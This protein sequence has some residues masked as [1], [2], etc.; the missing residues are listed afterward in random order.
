M[1]TDRR[2]DMTKIMVAFRNFANAPKNTDFIDAMTANVLSDL[3]FARNQLLKS[4][5]FRS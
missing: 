4:T 2:T 3:S 5:E 1:R